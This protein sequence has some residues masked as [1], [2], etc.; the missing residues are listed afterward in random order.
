MVLVVRFL[1][2]PLEGANFA[3]SSFVQKFAVGPLLV[4]VSVGP[5]DEAV[6][7][8]PLG[9]LDGRFDL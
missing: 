5:L 3:A 1:V 8:G 2:G 4:M 7:L 6:A 9:P